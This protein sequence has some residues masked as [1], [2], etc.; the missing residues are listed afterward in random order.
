MRAAVAPGQGRDRA[1]G[2]RSIADI[3]FPVGRPQTVVGRSGG[4]FLAA[5]ARGPDRDEH[6]H[7]L[8]PG[9]RR[10][11]ATARRDP[12]DAARS[13]CRRC[14][15]GAASRRGV[16]RRPRA[17]RLR[18]RSASRRRRRGR[19]MPGA[20]RAKGTCG[21]CC[22]ATDDMFVDL[23]PGR[24]DRAV[25]RRVGAA[26][27]SRPAGRGRSCSTPTAS[28]RRWTSRPPAPDTVAPLPFHGMTQL[29]V[30]RR[31]STIPRTPAHRDYLERYNTRI[32]ASPRAVA[33]PQ[34]ST[35][36]ARR[37]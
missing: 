4:Q 36:A 25:V 20:T 23:A 33:G 7:L 8:G 37:R 21:R 17:V 6:A 31:T 32:V 14:C 12:D 22:A 19:C 2:A 9:P 28:A 11:V 3:G 1:P 18:L 29:S 26:A 15:A 27:R 13:G 35:E 30:R 24:R 34:R 16:A 10:H 5:V